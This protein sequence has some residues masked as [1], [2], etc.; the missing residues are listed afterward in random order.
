MVT[1]NLICL[2]AKAAAG[3]RP[4]SFALGGFEPA[5]GWTPGWSFFIGLLPVSN[6]MSCKK[7][8]YASV[9]CGCLARYVEFSFDM[10]YSFSG[11][12]AYT[13]AAIGMSACISTHTFDHLPEYSRQL[14]AWRR[15]STTPLRSF[16]KQFHCRSRSGPSRASF[17]FSRFCSPCQ[18]SPR[19]YKVCVCMA[20]VRF[21]RS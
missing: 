1:V 17:F 12:T 21:G 14:P 16:R 10:L 3:R 5:S 9:G 15:R 18:M 19:Y 4:A 6:S 8:V 2:S 7:Q 13:Y 20:V 11:P